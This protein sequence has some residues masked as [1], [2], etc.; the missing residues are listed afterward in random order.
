MTDPIAGTD[1][2]EATALL[3]DVGRAVCTREL[4]DQLLLDALAAPG[5][6]GPQM[7]RLAD[8]VTGGD[9]VAAEQALIRVR[10]GGEGTQ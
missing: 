10:A 7:R 6:A 8:L 4:V 9:L 1:S 5:L 3:Y 2:A